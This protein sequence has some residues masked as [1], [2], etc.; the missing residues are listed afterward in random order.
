SGCSSAWAFV[1][2]E[3]SCSMRA[4]LQSACTGST[5]RTP[6]SRSARDTRP[7]GR[8]RY[9]PRTG[10]TSRKGVRY[11]RSRR[12]FAGRFRPVDAGYQHAAVFP[13]GLK[14]PHRRRRRW[15]QGRLGEAR[16]HS[17]VATGT[18]RGP[19]Y[20]GPAGRLQRT[21]HR[22]SLRTCVLH[23]GAVFEFRTAESRDGWRIDGAA[24]AGGSTLAEA[25][26]SDADEQPASLDGQLAARNGMISRFIFT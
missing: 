17:R 23:L 26:S 2:S 19:W 7:R 25:G 20:L 18:C 14:R 13:A 16:T 12:Y 11:G 15:L 22:L 21:D 8:P 1:S 24:P 10:G 9:T 4:S 5:C 6:A 3:C